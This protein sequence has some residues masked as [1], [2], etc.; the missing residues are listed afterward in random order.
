M[1]KVEKI[2]VLGVLFV[3]VSIL[4]L[5]LDGGLGGGLA[6]AGTG[7]LESASMGGQAT[8]N[9]GLQG[10]EERRERGRRVAGTSTEMDSPSEPEAGGPASSTMLTAEQRVVVDEPAL[11][12]LTQPAEGWDLVTLEG[13]EDHPFDPELKLYTALDGDDFVSLSERLYGDA[14]HASLLRCNNEGTLEIQAG[15]VLLVPVAGD[16]AGEQVHEVSSGDSLWKIAEQAYGKG[17]LWENIYD[18]NRDVLASPDDL[19]EGLMLRVPAL[20]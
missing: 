1:G 20:Q 19:R 4:A 17:Y 8:D 6:E 3:V 5:S 10:T 16:M 2:V 14:L 7:S 15:Q 18:A 13:L 9:S 12:R 11:T